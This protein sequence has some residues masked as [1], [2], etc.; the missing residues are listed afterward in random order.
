MYEVV[1][2][3]NQKQSQKIFNQ[4]KKWEYEFGNFSSKKN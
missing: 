1:A 2:V 4:I 3:V